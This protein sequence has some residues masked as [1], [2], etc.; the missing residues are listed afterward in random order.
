MS[1]LTSLFSGAALR[2]GIYVAA[3]AAVAAV[4]LGAK[5]AGRNAE[6]VD[7]LQRA[8]EIKDEQASVAR[9]TDDGLSRK[10][11]SGSF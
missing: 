4:L 5:R 1:F 6:R 8:L 10:L 11:R 7:N 2:I 9:P 3:A